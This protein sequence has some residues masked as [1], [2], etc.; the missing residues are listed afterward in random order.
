MK[1]GPLNSA[2]LAQLAKRFERAHAESNIS[3]LAILCV[4]AFPA[5]INQLRQL[6]AEHERKDAA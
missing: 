1:H 4:E 6:A 5:M 3:A 2:D